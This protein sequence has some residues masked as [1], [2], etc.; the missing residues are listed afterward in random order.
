LDT[1]TASDDWTL[2]PGAQVGDQIRVV[3]RAG[4]RAYEG[5]GRFG[6]GSFTTVEKGLADTRWS[7]RSTIL[8]VNGEAVTLDRPLP[9]GDIAYR[10][11]GVGLPA[12]GELSRA[13]AGA[14]G[15]A[16]ARVMADSAGR[17]QVAHHRAVDIRSD[18]RLMPQQSWTSS[19]TFISPCADPVVTAHLVHRPYPLAEARLRSWEGRDKL[20]VET[21]Q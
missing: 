3:E 12:D 15:F 20:M 18:N 14:P 11:D 8:G 1:K 6:D 5:P 16:F 2:W 7:G 13:W 19:H 17:E 10:V 9:A 21:S 4:F